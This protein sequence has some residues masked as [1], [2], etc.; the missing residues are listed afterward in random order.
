[1]SLLDLFIALI[2]FALGYYISSHFFATGQP[3]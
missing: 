1:V 2:G 3:A